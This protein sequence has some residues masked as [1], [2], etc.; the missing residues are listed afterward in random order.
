MYRI[1]DVL[2][3]SSQPRDK[4]WVSCITSRLF[5]TFP[6]E[7]RGKPTFIILNG[8]NIHKRSQNLTRNKTKTFSTFW[9]FHIV[10]TMR[11]KLSFVMTSGW[12]WWVS[13][14]EAGRYI[15]MM[16]FDPCPN[17]LLVI[18]QRLI[19]NHIKRVLILIPPCMLEEEG[20]PH[21]TKQISNTLCCVLSHSVVLDFLQP[22]EL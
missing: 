4:T 8:T 10:W 14:E 2:P 11:S 15:L 3:L 9:P 1:F 12:K 7:L 22:H 13:W 17:F 19:P 5:T 20:F 16:T 21:T 18:R 6:P